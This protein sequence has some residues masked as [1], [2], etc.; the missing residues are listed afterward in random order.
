MKRLLL[1]FAFCLLFA[2]CGKQNT[3][4]NTVVIDMT[5]EGLFLPC[6]D[7]KNIVIFDSYGPVELHPAD[8][9][10][11][12]FDGLTVGDRVSVNHGIIL[13]TYP[14][15][16]GITKIE[17]IS[18][19]SREDIPE[20]VVASLEELGRKVWPNEVVVEKID[21]SEVTYLYPYT[22]EDMPDEFFI[23]NEQTLSFD[24][25]YETG[26]CVIHDSEEI[27]FEIKDAEIQEVIKTSD[28]VYLFTNC[29]GRGTGCYMEELYKIEAPKY[30]PD[31]VLSYDTV[32]E[33][34]RNRVAYKYDKEY[35][36]LLLDTDS[37]K[38]KSLLLSNYL[39][40]RD[41]DYV[42]FGFG[43]IVRIEFYEEK[44]WIC[45]LGIIEFE[46]LPT[47]GHGFFCDYTVGVT[48]PI[49]LNDLSIG[50][51]NI[52][53]YDQ[54]KIF[55]NNDLN[56][57]L[58]DEI[59]FFYC[60]RDVNH[61]GCKDK[62]IL[63]AEI[64]QDEYLGS[65]DEVMQETME[66]SNARVFGGSYIYTD[67]GQHSFHDFASL[68]FLFSA[69][70]SGNGQL[71]VTTVDGADYLV[72]TSLWSGQG[73]SNYQYKVFFGDWQSEFVV[74]EKYMSFEYGNPT[75]NI[76]EFWDG[77]YKWINDSSILLIA[78]DI[79]SHPMTYYSTTESILNPEIFYNKKSLLK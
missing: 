49:D 73:E 22:E 53:T 29:C 35:E 52:F 34:L 19:G 17:K 25:D 64:I 66:V 67:P 15:S 50:D 41:F 9:N 1:I 77:L 68:E 62:I 8:G 28:E 20:D 63:S 39:E 54:S 30:I 78:A 24:Y 7:G 6:E 31:K 55:N 76:D 44:P 11:I 51:L 75:E 60:Y 59:P 65:F 38:H 26:I 72:E 43:D 21:K 33:E 12:V 40:S 45:A 32:V 71:F 3:H 4:D 10:T 61:D 42:N 13:E 16:T 74:E 46:D 57:C 47:G 69:S 56:E 5:S 48:A 58:N 18:D 79:D 36:V 14:G 23:P 27:S 70:H 2:G 37:R